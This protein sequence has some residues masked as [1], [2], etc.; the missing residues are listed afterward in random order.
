MEGLE[1]MLRSIADRGYVVISDDVSDP[2]RA[3]LV[4]VHNVGAVVS[5]S[6]S[7]PGIPPE[8]WG[9]GADAL[10]VAS[11]QSMRLLLAEMLK[12]TLPG[13]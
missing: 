13:S 11:S 2:A 10:L 6:A 3:R 12:G 7:A 8:A 9:G 5:S 1:G 4:S